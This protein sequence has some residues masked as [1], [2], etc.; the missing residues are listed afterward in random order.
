VFPK[1][2]SIGSFFLPTYGV[3][4]A[5]GFLIGLWVAARLAKRSGLDPDRVVNLGVYSALAGLLGAKLLMFVVDFDHYRNNPGEIFSLATIQAGGVFYGGLVLALIAGLLT[6]YRWSMPIATTLD[7]LAPGAAIGQAIGR[8]GCFA[9]G[10]CWGRE[11]DRSWAVT[12]NNPEAYRLVGVPLGIPLHP[13]QIYE[14]I[15]GFVIFGVLWWLSARPRFPGL[16]LGWYLLLSS[17]ARFVVEFFRA[18]QQ[19]NPFGWTLSTA[20]WI[21]MGLFLAGTAILARGRSRRLVTAKSLS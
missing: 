14:A 8:L 19:D 4:V 6:L 5:L 9:A 15:G 11:C 21:S 1:I 16:I 7:V 18:H 3:L 12:F 2:F 13:T 10:C 17:T 20:Q